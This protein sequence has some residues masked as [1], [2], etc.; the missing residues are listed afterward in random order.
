MSDDAQRPSRWRALLRPDQTDAASA[1]LAVAVALL[2]DVSIWRTVLGLA[3]LVLSVRW[4]AEG[5]RRS[6]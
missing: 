5:V 4:M 1:G 2:T 6:G 3:V